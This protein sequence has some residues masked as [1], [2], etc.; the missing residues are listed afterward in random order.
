MNLKG[1]DC[2]VLKRYKFQ[3]FC[4]LPL[5]H[6]ITILSSLYQL[7]IIIFRQKTLILLR[8]RLRFEISVL[9]VESPFLKKLKKTYVSTNLGISTETKHS[10]INHIIKYEILI[11]ICSI[12]LNILNIN[13]TQFSDTDI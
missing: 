8:K 12:Q 2:Y 5:L 9:Y 10:F 1:P 13:F 4:L 6:K 3:Q 11:I 7:K